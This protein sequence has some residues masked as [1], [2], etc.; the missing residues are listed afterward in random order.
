M[1]GF[2]ALLFST[3]WILS[4]LA[5]LPG[6]WWLL[7]ITPPKP[8]QIIFPALLLMKGIKSTED[9]PHKT[10]WWLLLLRIA[11]A[12]LIILAAAGPS[13]HQGKPQESTKG[14]LVLIVDTGWAAASHWSKR[15]ELANELIDRAERNGNPVVLFSSAAPQGASSFNPASA[16]E[17]RSKLAALAP[18]PFAPVRSKIINALLDANSLIENMRV[19]WLSDGI[20]Y[21]Q[22]DELDKAL[23]ALIARGIE[24]TVHQPSTGWF[25]LVLIPPQPKEGELTVTVLST[26]PASG[27]RTGAIRSFTADGRQIEDTPFLMSA[28]AKQVDVNIRL[29]LRLR[30]KIAR[31]EIVGGQTAAGVVLLDDRNRRKPVGMVEFPDQA[32]LSLLAPLYYAEKAIRPVTEIRR[33]SRIEELATPANDIIFLT[34]TGRLTDIQQ[35]DLSRWIDSGGMLI[36]FAGSRMA[37]GTDQLIP[38]RLRQ[39]GR[40]LGG[41][42]SWDTPQKLAAFDR[43]SPFAGLDAPDEVTV[44]RQVLAE[45]SLDLADKT[46]ARLS[47]GTPL[48]TAK[49][50][51]RGW[52]ILFHTTANTE[53]TNLPLSG[54][55]VEMMHRLIALAPGIESNPGA[56]AEPTP[57]LPQTLSPVRT[58][59]GFGRLGKPPATAEPIILK[60]LKLTLPGPNHPPGY[61][62]PERGGY[63]FNLLNADS[64]IKVLEKP[65][66]AKLTGY[67]F[68]TTLDVSGFILLAAL[69]LF[70]ADGLA[71]LPLS[72][73]LSA[74]KRGKTVAVIFAVAAASAFITGNPGWAQ[75]ASTPDDFAIMATRETRLAYVK[76]GNPEIDEIS[77]LGLRSLSEALTRRTSFEPGDPIAVS[78][79]KDE[80]AFFP[81]LYWPVV[82]ALPDP[83][84][85]TISRINSFMKSGGTILFD[86]RD[87]QLAIP[88]LPEIRNTPNREALR[89]LLSRLDIPPMEHVPAE[90]VLGKSFYLMSKFPGR[91]QNG[92][93]WTETNGTKRISGILVGSNDYAAAWA[94]DDRG[95][96]LF[97]VTPGGEIQRE[98]ALRA[99]VNIVLYA[100]T[101]NYKADQVHVP[102]ILKRLGR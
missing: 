33:N 34:D 45:P 17:A 86:T 20:D 102:A 85:E 89:A 21:G 80:L 18:F 4:T 13:L 3:P 94:R 19:H 95:T 84:P 88:A 65:D 51:G 23:S 61:Y 100:L 75:G 55:F 101:G 66:G 31:F 91:W 40:S 57:R 7:R 38:V 50:N 25:P 52:I 54:L 82:S 44:S 24:V 9:T 70:L 14:T 68:G 76:T 26:G 2:D 87:A 32:G 56:L 35:E 99:G 97:P 10:P 96:W 59:N 47:D 92:P 36:R 16:A 77:R 81:F 22:D 8:K 90:H 15:I 71:R 58:L 43:D 12:F 63:A 93:L 60:D 73:Q 62:G 42:L 5:L 6:L 30:N 78:I 39:G 11:I 46:W 48:V 83:G 1:L 67:G 74:P 41:A 49:R 37:A 79:S 27:P 29:P 28:G 69:I 72:N 98:Q 64:F 53:W